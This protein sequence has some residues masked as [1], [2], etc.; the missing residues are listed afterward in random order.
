MKSNAWKTGTGM[1]AGRRFWRKAAGMAL[2]AAVMAGMML[3]AVP[4]N[5]AAGTQT[6]TEDGSA[7]VAVT[8][9]V[10]EKVT[11]D[12]TV[13]LPTS[14]NLEYDS[15]ADN[16]Q[17]VLDAGVYG[18]VDQSCVVYTRIAADSDALVSK[19]SSGS[20]IEGV[21]P[22]GTGDTAGTVTRWYKLTDADGDHTE[23]LTAVQSVGRSHIMNWVDSAVTGTLAAGE[24]KMAADSTAVERQPIASLSADLTEGGS[25]SGN[26]MVEF[27]VA[28]K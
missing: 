16:Y 17:G 5:A 11:A 4:A 19:D 26:V 1:A 6:F 18:T 15:D 25:Y 12:Y 9:T 3:P 23:Y 2:S 10:P 7:K 24:M 27:G 22:D 20:F 21:A 14:V 28:E 8:A 13:V